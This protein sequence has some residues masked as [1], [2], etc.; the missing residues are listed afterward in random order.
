MARINNQ[1]NI[2]MQPSWQLTKRH[3][4]TVA[5]QTCLPRAEISGMLDTNRDKRSED[6]DVHLIQKCRCSVWMSSICSESHVLSHALQVRSLQSKM[7]FAETT[8]RQKG[9][10]LILA[11]ANS[12]CGIHIFKWQSSK[13]VLLMCCM[14]QSMKTTVCDRWFQY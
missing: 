14:S 1:Y 6:S 12:C 10:G 4:C 2:C 5:V 9:A 8:W 3:T 7:K 13:Q 11:M